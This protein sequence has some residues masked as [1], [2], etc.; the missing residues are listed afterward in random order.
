MDENDII[1]ELANR[2]GVAVGD[3]FNIFSESIRGM[4]VLDMVTSIS[5]LIVF[6]FSYAVLSILFASISITLISLDS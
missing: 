4:A 5:M 3:I 1:I 6:V 2:L